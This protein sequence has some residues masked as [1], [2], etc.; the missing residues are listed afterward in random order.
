MWN[1]INMNP[2]PL[3]N[4]LKGRRIVFPSVLAFSVSDMKGH[5]FTLRE[6]RE[7]VQQFRLQSALAEFPN[8]VSSTIPD[9]LQSP[10]TSNCW[11]SDALFLPPQALPAYMHTPKETHIPITKNNTNILK[12]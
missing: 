2:K 3:T 9:S 8:S 6:T 5:A 1:Q 7:M 4:R 12:Y 10:A 11:K